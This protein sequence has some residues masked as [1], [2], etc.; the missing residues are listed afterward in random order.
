MGLTEFKRSGTL[1]WSVRLS[2]A[3][4]PAKMLSVMSIPLLLVACQTTG[5]TVTS[6]KAQCAPWRPITYSSSK[7]TGETVK[8]S[9]V[10]NRVGQRLGCWK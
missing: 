10:H 9:R 6:T 2:A 4:K 5:T 7:D 3:K 1:H 8:Q